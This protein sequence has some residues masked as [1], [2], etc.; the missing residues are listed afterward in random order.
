MTPSNPATSAG[1]VRA[2]AVLIMLFLFQTLNFFDK[3]VFG[4]SAVPMM[5]ELGLTPQQFGLIGSSFFL[6]FSLSGMAVGLFVIGR[7]PTKWILIILAGIWSATQLPIFFSSSVA[8]LVVCRILLGAGEGPGLPTALH[9]CY[10]WFAADKRSVPSAV[11]LQGISVGLLAGGPF[12]TYIIVNYGWRTGFLVC[13]LLGLAWMLGWLFIGGEGP[14]AATAPGQDT[15]QAG[16][17]VPT[18][19]LWGDPT[20]IGVIIMSTMS[21]W[22]VGMSATWLPPYLQLG[23]GYQPVAVGWIIF[24][25]YLFQSPLL[26]GG[27]WVTQLMQRSGFS[28]RTCLGNASGLALLVAGIALLLTLVTTGPL[29]LACIALAF[30]APSLTTIFGPVALGAVAPAAQRGKLIV[31]IYS[32]NAVSALVSNALTGWIVGEAGADVTRGYAHAMTFTAGILLIG[33]VSAFALIFPERTIARFARTVRPAATATTV[34][35]T[36]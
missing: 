28:L 23:L 4:L 29:Q 25:I 33:A 11:V 24:G 16:A 12:L 13:G 9:A 27:S 18:A 32:G 3:L 5:K 8:V 36:S 2:F 6:L 21:Y 34:P 26:L 30:A 22:I 31:V 35:A 20:V 17:T 10:N 19:M 15:A 14:Y 7:V 1:G